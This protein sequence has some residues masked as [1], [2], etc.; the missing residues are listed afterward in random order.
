MKTL[1]LRAKLF[2]AGLVILLNSQTIQA[3]NELE[4]NTNR[5]NLENSLVSNP[6]TLL[7]LKICEDKS[8]KLTADDFFSTTTNT[9]IQCEWKSIEGKIPNFGYS[10]STFWIVLRLKNLTTIPLHY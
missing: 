10:T 8:S 2:L 6:I 5:I 4:S 1:I 3:Y 7:N 9:N